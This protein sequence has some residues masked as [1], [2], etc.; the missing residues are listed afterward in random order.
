MYFIRFLIHEDLYACLAWCFRHNI[1]SAWFLDIRISTCLY[2]EFIIY[3]IERVSNCNAIA[4]HT[5]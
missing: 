1:C 2:Q 4:K 5:V 3:N